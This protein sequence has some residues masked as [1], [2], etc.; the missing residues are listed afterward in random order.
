MQVYSEKEQVGKEEIQNIQFE[1][2]MSTRKFNVETK[3]GTERNKDIKKRKPGMCF[4][5]KGKDA[6]R[7]EPHPVKLPT[8]ERK[9]PK[10]CYALEEQQ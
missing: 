2:K 3:A 1:D 8:C 5:K 7:A 4:V 6:F 10:K 9:R